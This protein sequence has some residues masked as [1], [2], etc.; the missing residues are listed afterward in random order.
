MGCR[1]VVS[2]Y[3]RAICLHVRRHLYKLLPSACLCHT[4]ILLKKRSIPVCTHFVTFTDSSNSIQINFGRNRIWPNTPAI[5]SVSIY[6]SK[7]SKFEALKPRP[8][9]FGMQELRFRPLTLSATG[10]CQE[11]LKGTM[12]RKGSQ[13]QVLHGPARPT[14]KVRNNVNP[15][16]GASY[17]V[18]STLTALRQ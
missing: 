14:N 11:A 12:T 7:C 10:M 18:T 4:R 13:V 6:D 9:Y 17:R 15:F 2:R 5:V 8:R 1:T 16:P 3:V